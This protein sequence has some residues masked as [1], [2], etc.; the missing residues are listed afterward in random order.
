MGNRKTE[1]CRKEEKE[2]FILSFYCYLLLFLWLLGTE[3]GGGGES[4][5]SKEI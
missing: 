3:R 4:E 2:G 1:R 5:N